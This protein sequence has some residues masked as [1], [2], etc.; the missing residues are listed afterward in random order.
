MLNDRPNKFI[1]TVFECVDTGVSKGVF[2]VIYQDEKLD[3]RS[4]T[5]DGKRAVNFG[6]CSYLGF[7]LD[8]RLRQASIEA[9]EKYGV[10]YSSSRA[11]SACPLYP[12]V[13]SLLSK[14]FD[15]NPMVLAATTTLNHIGVLPV[16]LQEKDLII[17]DQKVHGSIQ[18][19]SQ[20]L[21]ARGAQ[22]EMIRHNNM[23]MLEEKILENP[24]KYD[25]IWYMADGVYSMFGDLAPM[26]DL[27]YLLDK[28]ENFHLYI[29]DA[30]G[31]SWTGK[32][33]RGTVMRNG[34]LHPKIF[35]TTSFGKGFGVGGGGFVTSS[36]AMRQKILTCGTSYTFSGPVQPPLLGAIAACAKIHLTDEITERQQLLQHK[37][38]W[39]KRLCNELDLPEVYPSETP[40]FYFALGQPRV[41]YSII[42]RL[43][44]D[45]FYT[46]IGI[47]PTVPVNNTGLRIPI[48]LSQTDEDIKNLL[49][50]FAYH[51]PRV[52]KDEKVTME[53]LSRSFKHDF[54]PT[55][56]RYFSKV[57]SPIVQS[58]IVQHETSINMI[59]K[60][61]WNKLLGENGSFD[62]NGCKFIEEAFSN[63]DEESNWKL[64]YVI[65]K[66][67]KGNP[68]LATFFSV[69][70]SKDDMVSPEA[71]SKEIEEKRKK[72]PYYLTSKVVSMGSLI[73][74]GA[75]L[76]LD[77]KHSEWKTAL[78][79]LLKIMDDVKHAENASAIQLRDFDTEDIEL[80][81]FLIQ[82][83]FFRADLPDSH[84]ISNQNWI[85]SEDYIESLSKKSRYHVRKNMAK[86]ENFFD[87]TV[88]SISSEE[89][90]E[91]IY[92]LYL[93]I[94]RG[95]FKINTFD[96]PI[97]FFEFAF[98][99]PDWELIK[100][101][102]SE[103]NHLCCFVLCYI[104]EANNYS[105]MVIGL[106]YDYNAKYNC[107]RQG[108][109]Q[110]VNRAI[111]RKTNKV[112]LGMDA[113]IEKQKLG[114]KVHKKS[115]YLQMDDNFALETIS[116]LKQNDN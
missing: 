11:Y 53:Q 102:L 90:I 66:D 54:S 94:K 5:V 69:L 83:G 57:E 48:T 52:L 116:I 6:S 113:S 81:D 3:G 30:H 2:Q 74:E 29:D 93:N 91:K 28:Y 58:C 37:I 60:E 17:L 88:E 41:G 22:L 12:E 98:K 95:S 46:N 71:V 27:L 16:L 55:I 20:L 45:G 84:I 62:W 89:E 35:L 4:L 97:R 18:M 107:Y 13:E 32:H 108:L 111:Y 49:E 39:T 33:G 24:N 19:A 51:F 75:H 114:A 38:D 100:I 25:Q 7:E 115:I 65:V 99:S 10:H 9:I 43:L 92:N 86:Q 42:Q 8:Q 15:D 56:E 85:N 112:Y 47:F 14:I 79:R 64:H 21:K 67:S 87:I 73:T 77:R 105:P 44:N 104:S 106:D 59:D 82:E 80:R 76:Y 1:D 31:M 23:Q 110:I 96:L 101:R 50:A 61:L 103:D 109:F 36:E 40:I 26:D 70:L 34:G 68:I 63:N 72:D 78:R